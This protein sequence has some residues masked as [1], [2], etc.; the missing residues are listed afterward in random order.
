MKAARKVV[1]TTVAGVSPLVLTNCAQLSHMATDDIVRLSKK[2]MCRLFVDGETI[3]EQGATAET[4]FILLDG[5]IRL[6]RSSP[7][8]RGVDY[9]VETAY[10]TFGDMVLLGEEDRRYTATAVRDSLVIEL[11]LDVVAAAIEKNPP[12]GVAWR[13]SIMARLHRREPQDSDTFAWRILD[14]L[15]QLTDAA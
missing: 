15:S 14:K 8:G 4:V 9:A 6:E 1:H 3:F 5:A 7:E 11:P 12:Q 10:S 2:A 13:G